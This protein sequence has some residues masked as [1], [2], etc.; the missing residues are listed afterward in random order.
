MG[1]TF[2]TQAKIAI[3][4]KKKLLL[5]TYSAKNPYEYYSI[6]VLQY[7]SASCVLLTEP[8]SSAKTV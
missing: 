7:Y 1:D 6:T 5:Y 3:D 8:K 2:A 4:N